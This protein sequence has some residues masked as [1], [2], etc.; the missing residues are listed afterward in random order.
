MVIPQVLSSDALHTNASLVQLKRDV[1]VATRGLG[2][3]CDLEETAVIE[4]IGVHY[5][6]DQCLLFC[7]LT[8]WSCLASVQ[9]STAVSVRHAVQTVHRA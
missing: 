2:E 5:R 8:L 3:G 9:R 1:V 7:L 4:Q 6:F